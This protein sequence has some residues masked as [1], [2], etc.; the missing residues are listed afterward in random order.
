MTPPRQRYCNDVENIFVNA[1]KL[2]VQ[3]S[4]RD[5]TGRVCFDVFDREGAYIDRLFIKL[6][7]RTLQLGYH[8]LSIFIA[9]NALLALEK[10]EDETFALVKYVIID[11]I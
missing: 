11:R 10:N 9:G 3:T 4:T 1:G 8:P 7:D 6:P 5:D 2:W